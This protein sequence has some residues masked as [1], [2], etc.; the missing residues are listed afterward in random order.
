MAF[1]SEDSPFMEADMNP[2]TKVYCKPFSMNRE[3]VVVGMN[4]IKPTFEMKNGKYVACTKAGTMLV[5]FIPIFINDRN[6]R[7]F[8]HMDKKYFPL[9]VEQIGEILTLNTD[10]ASLKASEEIRE[11]VLERVYEN[12]TGRER[13]TLNIIE[14][15]GFKF[16]LNYN[17]EIGTAVAKY[18]LDVSLNEMKVI[19]SL[20]NYSIPL[21]L[22][23]NAIADPSYALSQ[24]KGFNRDGFGR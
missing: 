20:C 5:E 14:K 10:Y 17:E 16:E 8:G 3:N 7:V 9:T 4:L 15:E 22:G 18:S 11:I 6:E 21:L 12:E 19:H 24:S 23:W 1:R 13:K 2:I